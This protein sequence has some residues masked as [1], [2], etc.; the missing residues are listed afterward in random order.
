MERQPSK[1]LLMWRE[2]ERRANEDELKMLQELLEEM[3]SSQAM[4]GKTMTSPTE[5]DP[6]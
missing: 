5:K 6:G 1:E 2:M 4:T 3:N